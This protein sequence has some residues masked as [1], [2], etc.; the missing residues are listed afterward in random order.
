[1]LTYYG[2]KDIMKHKK[3]AFLCS[4]TVPADIVMR[5]YEWAVKQREKGDC[6]VCG[7][8]S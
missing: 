5:S 3:I 8:Y 1:M 7:N 6:I 4:Q 2:N